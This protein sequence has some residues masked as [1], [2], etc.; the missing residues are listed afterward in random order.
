MLGRTRALARAVCDERWL[1]RA[2]VVDRGA[3]ALLAV[4]RRFDCAQLGGKRASSVGELAS[5]VEGARE[6]GLE[7]VGTDKHGA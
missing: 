3:N 4:A 2:V 7:L 5:S 6:H 1:V